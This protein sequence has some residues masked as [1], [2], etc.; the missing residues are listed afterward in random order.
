MEE[1]ITDK[2]DDL[3]AFFPADSKDIYFDESYIKLYEN[4]SNRGFCY[5]YREN[6][7]ILLFPFLRRSFDFGQNV[8]YDFETAYGYG[9]PITNTCYPAF[10]QR[11]LTSLKCFFAQEGYVAGFIRFHPLLN[12]QSLFQEDDHSILRDRQT[13]AMNLEMGEEDIWMKEIHTKNRN[14][15]KKGMKNGLSF[16]VDKKYEYLDEFIKLYNSTMQK[17]SADDFYFFTD[18]YY[19]NL[20]RSLKN[21]FLGVVLY[22][23]KVI[24]GAMFFYSENYGH[25]HLSG[26]DINYLSLCPNNYM[27]YEAALELKKRGVRK[28]HL[29]G[30]TTANA[31]DSLFGFKKHFSKNYYWFSIGKLI[32]NKSVYDCLCQNWEKKYP[33]RQSK[34]KCFLLKYKY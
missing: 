3:L 13:V 7:A 19:K 11:A 5:V 32:F 18:D 4:D 30:G 22:E 34:Y 9:G 31:N 25:Y 16:V 33:E 1:F 21:N 14:V 10:I 15:I 29:G 6:E 2:W 27:L 28:F 26:S 23:G 8:Y 12:N 24:S 20:I 17:L